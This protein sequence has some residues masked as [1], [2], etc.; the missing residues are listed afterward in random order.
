MR[1]DRSFSESTLEHSTIHRVNGTNK[2]S[3]RGESLAIFKSIKESYRKLYI[4]ITL[5]I[6]RSKA[7]N[8]MDSLA[9]LQ[10]FNLHQSSY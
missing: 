6:R 3:R 10:K 5:L 4:Q 1:S 8:L 7:L 9:K 2:K